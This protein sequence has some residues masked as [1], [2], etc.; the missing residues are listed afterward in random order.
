MSAALGATVLSRLT[1]GAMEAVLAF[2]LAALLYLVT[3]ELLREA[4]REREST[5]GTVL[6]FVGFLGFL[7]VGMTLDLARVET[8]ARDR[9]LT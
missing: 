1:G 6:F 7:V 9:A 4:H 3:E 5:V 2:G 8:K